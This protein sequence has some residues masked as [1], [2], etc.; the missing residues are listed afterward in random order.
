MEKIVE[1]S[2]YLIYDKPRSLP[3]PWR[4]IRPSPSTPDQQI[5]GASEDD[6]IMKDGLLYECCMVDGW[7]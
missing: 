5:G 1:H 2:V 7:I 6:I 3:P 4:F